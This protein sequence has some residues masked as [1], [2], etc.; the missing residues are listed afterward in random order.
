M[1]KELQQ[2]ALDNTADKPLKSF[3]VDVKGG[4]PEAELQKAEQEWLGDTLGL[5]KENVIFAIQNQ[6]ENASDIVIDDR[7]TAKMMWDITEQFD[8]TIHWL[9]ERKLI[10][11]DEKQMLEIIHARCSG[12]ALGLEYGGK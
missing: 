6:D 12:F 11:S 5:P 10:R 3:D 7:T 9:D 1:A 2:A 4:M 8:S